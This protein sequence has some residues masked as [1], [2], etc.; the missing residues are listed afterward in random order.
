MVE[1]G[2]AWWSKC[3]LLVLHASLPTSS[4]TAEPRPAPAPSGH[5]QMRLLIRINVCLS[6]C[7]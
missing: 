7:H 4:R 2:G 5:S 3:Q 1:R 6:G